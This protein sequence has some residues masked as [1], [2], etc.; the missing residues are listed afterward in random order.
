MPADGRS[1]HGDPLSSLL[2]CSIIHMV[3][4][5][6]GSV[7][8]ADLAKNT[9]ETYNGDIRKKS[10]EDYYYGNYGTAY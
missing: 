8:A 7:N 2:F 5:G 6:C 10:E 3:T 9:V 1:M 4:P